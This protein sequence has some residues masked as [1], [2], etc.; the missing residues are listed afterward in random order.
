MSFQVRTEPAIDEQISRLPTSLQLQIIRKLL[1]LGQTP[2]D[3]S[4][5]TVGMV[6]RFALHY[7]DMTLYVDAYFKYGQD[8]ESIVF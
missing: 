2:R 6:F 4:L 8:E 5:T 3:A 7:D 1:L